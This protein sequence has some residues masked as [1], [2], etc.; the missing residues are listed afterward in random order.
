M[1]E[2]EFSL[3]GT[4]EYAER[5][6][7]V[8]R[9]W[10]VPLARFGYATKGIVYIIIGLLAALAA[11]HKGGRTTDSHGAFTEILSQP[12][13]QLLLGAVA[14]GL[15]GYALWCFIQAIKDTEHKGST[16]KGIVIR[17]GYGAVGL[18][19]TSLA[20]TAMQLIIGSRGSYKGEE[21][22]REWT[23]TLLAQPF[24]Q[25]FVG[26]VGVA[27]IIAAIIQ[28]YQAYT[29]KF[30]GELKRS[31]MGARAESW[32]MQ[33]GRIGLTARG[34]VFGM[35]GVFLLL[36][37]I[38]ADPNEARGLSGALRILEQQPFGPWV[39]GIVALGLANYGIYM[40]VL[41]GYR[42]IRV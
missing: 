2:P 12:Y 41:A 26:T 13:G 32:A 30:R 14:A 1:R 24:G 3:Q 31:E 16:A 42:R 21:S 15:A 27:I 10:V 7:Y 25:W 35:M 40:L 5:I 9:D 17:L 34:I 22:S 23:A 39:L 11:F 36:A 18:I 4:E 33:V 28:C 38:H 29:G 8:A 6:S 20:V 37:A 19:H